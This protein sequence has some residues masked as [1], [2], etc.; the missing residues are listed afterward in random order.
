MTNIDTSYFENGNLR[1]DVIWSPG[2]LGSYGYM[3]T[4]ALS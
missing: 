4:P 3:I 1:Y 2:E